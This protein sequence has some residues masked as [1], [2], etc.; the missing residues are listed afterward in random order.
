MIC[1]GIA[2]LGAG[3]AVTRWANI[4]WGGVEIFDSLRDTD[5]YILAS[6][7]QSYKL[8]KYTSIYMIWFF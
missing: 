6:R 7:I 5:T 2:V 3:Y 1:G 8:F 4:T